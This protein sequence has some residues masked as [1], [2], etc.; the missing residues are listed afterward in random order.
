M[1]SCYNFKAKLVYF[2]SWLLTNLANSFANDE[3]LSY[4]HPD[5]VENLITQQA[6]VRIMNNGK[7]HNKYNATLS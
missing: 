2:S 1:A 7:D 6:N 4:S 5:L 3:L